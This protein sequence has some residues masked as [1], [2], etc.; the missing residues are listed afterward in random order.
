MKRTTNLVL[1]RKGQTVATLA[2]LRG[3]SLRH[4]LVK[5]VLGNFLN[6]IVDCNAEDGAGET[7]IAVMEEHVQNSIQRDWEIDQ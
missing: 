7:L 3:K 6:P 1:G 4:C 2:S 5:F